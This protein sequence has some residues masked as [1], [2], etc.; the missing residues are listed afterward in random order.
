MGVSEVIE[1]FC[2]EN[3]FCVDKGKR[4]GKQLFLKNLLCV[5]R[6]AFMTTAQPQNRPEVGSKFQMGGAQK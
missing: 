6:V 5:W 1:I 3:V 4:G 2:W